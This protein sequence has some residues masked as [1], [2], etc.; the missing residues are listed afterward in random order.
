MEKRALIAVALS[1]LILWIYQAYLAPKPTPTPAQ[2]R[3]SK[4]A[5]ETQ[6]V[7]QAGGP[8]EKSSAS[9]AASALTA[10]TN[11]PAADR[12]YKIRVETRL[13]KAVF[14]NKGARLL[15]FKLKE[16]KDSDPKLIE[17]VNAE[18]VE[19]DLLPF[20]IQ[21]PKEQLT[22]T[23]NGALFGCDK[24]NVVLESDGMSHITMHAQLEGG[25]WVAKEFEFYPYSYDI[26]VRVTGAPELGPLALRL[27]PG[28]GNPTI[29]QAK[30]S[31]LNRGSIVYQSLGK[32]VR[33][34]GKAGGDVGEVNWLGVE[35]NYFMML[36]RF[37]VPVR[38]A[39]STPYD[40]VHG[41]RAA[42]VS[43]VPSTPFWVF[44]GPKDYTLLKQ[45]NDGLDRLVDYG[46]FGFLAKP[47]LTAL[48][49]LYK[50]V[51]NYGFAIII[52][53]LAIK[54]LLFPLTY[55]SS[56]SM[57]K[58]QQVQPE[59]QAI[60]DRY[61]KKK[62][63]EDR[64]KMNQEIM[65]LYKERGINP[66]GGCIP[67]LIQMPVLIAFYNLLSVSIELRG[68]PFVGWLTDLSAADPYFITPI[69]MG[70]T[71][72]VLQRMSP[73]PA[74]AVQ[75][76]MMLIMPVFFTI[77]FINIQSGLVLYWTANN[78]LQILQQYVMM[79]MGLVPARNS[80]RKNK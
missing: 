3:T 50:Y 52:L 16:Y 29:R 80:A 39:T 49:F 38:A 55:S 71:Q 21:S 73:Q 5:S 32:I 78:G 13:Y 62:G 77:L 72:L 35:D 68:A 6:P 9:E 28:L 33:D 40:A 59:M 53:T 12:E 67:I 19:K 51:H 2:T 14:T 65:K 37:A 60:R 46:W 22:K 42:I 47:L 30:N 34:S 61:S 15:S 7:P 11:I 20:A 31:R 66:M 27:G 56:I 58:V 41:T 18:A 24:D 57:L 69:L 43:E 64:Q 8:E 4:V 45:L 17:I 76:K 25:A 36:A 63:I 75:A 79:R 1:F 48:Q 70:A 10:P 23:I 44:I 26:K 54:I 74:D